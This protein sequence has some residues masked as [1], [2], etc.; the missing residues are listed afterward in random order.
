M[1][2]LGGL[3]ICRACRSGSS[4][5]KCAATR[6]QLLTHKKTVLRAVGMPITGHSVGGKVLGSQDPGAEGGAA[7]T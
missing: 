7:S 2:P 4:A 6:K 5:L 3:G 1:D